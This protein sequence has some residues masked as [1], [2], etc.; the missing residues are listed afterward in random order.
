MNKH[1]SFLIGL[2]FALTLTS[3]PWV[4][5]FCEGQGR[6]EPLTPPTACSFDSNY[7]LEF[8][9]DSCYLQIRNWGNSTCNLAFSFD[10]TSWTAVD[11]D[12]VIWLSNTQGLN[13]PCPIVLKD[14][15]NP[16]KLLPYK[17]QSP[18][19]CTPPFNAQAIYDVVEDPISRSLTA[20]TCR[21]ADFMFVFPDGTEVPAFQVS[22]RL[23]LDKLNDI[24]YSVDSI[25]ETNQ[26]V[27]LR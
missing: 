13:R 6:N 16:G 4:L 24:Q 11:G 26:T 10:N 19:N 23:H 14:V 20:E 7:E 1:S 17:G 25:D 8:N 27:F 22:L 9:S 15:L 2:L 21:C 5:H 3:I 18:C 12:G